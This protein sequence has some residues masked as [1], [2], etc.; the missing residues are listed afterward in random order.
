M[1]KVPVAL[2]LEPIQ[3]LCENDSGTL[4]LRLGT[5]NSWGM[6]SEDNIFKDF[7]C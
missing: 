1:Q 5:L 3:L 7:N 4:S 6:V 2:E